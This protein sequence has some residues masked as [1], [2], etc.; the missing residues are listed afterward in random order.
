[1]LYRPFGKTGE[2]VSILG[3]G[4]MRMPVLDHRHDQVDVPLA[5][6]MIRHAIDNGV[7]YVDTAYVYHGASVTKPGNSESVVGQALSDGYRDKV[8]LATK[9]VGW[10]VQSR[11]DMDRVLAEQ[12]AK[13]RTDHLDCYLLH[14]IGAEGWE[15]FQKLGALDFLDAAKADGRIRF[16]GFS[17][18]DESEAF[19]P[20]VDGYDW[21]FC[22]IQYN[23][24]DVDYQAGRTGLRY[25][26]S[27]GLGIIIME[28]IKGG[29]L[30]GRA[31]DEVQQIWDAAPVSRSPAEWALRYV[32][33]DPDVDV[34]LSG[35]S[36]MQQLIDNLQA[37]AVAHPQSLSA[38]EL[39][40]IEQ[41][42][43]VYD[44]RTAVPCTG[45]RYCMP[46]P[47]GIDIPATLALM[48]D[49]SLYG[50]VQGERFTYKINVDLGN[51]APASACTECGQ[52]VEACP[53][54]IA[55]PEALAECVRLFEAEAPNMGDPAVEQVGSA[56]SPE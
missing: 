21:D 10:S 40:V 53:Q 31:P 56:E 54:Q 41:V 19:R 44:E 27:R 52:C 35:M 24:M 14:G 12:L 5:V 2:K 23:Y 55:V 18:H 22:Q 34:V 45:C 13:L 50:N 25:A 7:N 47:S 16:A 3:F 15:R 48:N 51:S 29:R 36:T 20:I 11:A 39:A 1:M 42:R 32:W 30:A 17:F 9:L 26:A 46:C 38:S 4:A 49:A 33:D 8:M 43:R 37:A 28:P 6:D